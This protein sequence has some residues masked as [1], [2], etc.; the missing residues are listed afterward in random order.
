M[1]SVR[2]MQPPIW[3]ESRPTYGAYLSSWGTSCGDSCSRVHYY[4]AYF[5]PR[6]RLR[7]SHRRRRSDDPG[8]CAVARQRAAGDRAGTGPLTL[9]KPLRECRHPSSCCAA[10]VWFGT[11]R[12][13]FGLSLMVLKMLRTRGGAGPRFAASSDGYRLIGGVHGLQERLGRAMKRR[14]FVTCDSIAIK[15]PVMPALG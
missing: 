11:K 9:S 8:P 7:R 3:E 10:G 14:D 1:P 6:R 12:R 15:L 5:A 13:S 4:P 2:C